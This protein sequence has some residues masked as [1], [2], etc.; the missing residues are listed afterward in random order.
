MVCVASLS[1]RWRLFLRR[2][3]AA[4]LPGEL[5]WARDGCPVWYAGGAGSLRW[6]R[7]WRCWRGGCRRPCPAT[8]GPPPRGGVGPGPPGGG[9]RFYWGGSGG[10][11]GGGGGGRRARGGRRGGGGRGGRGR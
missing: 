10:G 9:G 8:A 5:L 6:W 3:V 2:R 4:N 7:R 1:C 11:G